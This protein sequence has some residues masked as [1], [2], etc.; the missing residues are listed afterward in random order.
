MIR[1]VLG[2]DFKVERVNTVNECLVGE[3]SEDHTVVQRGDTVVG[4]VAEEA[5]RVWE[6]VYMNEF[7]KI[8]RRRLMKGL[9]GE[10]QNLK[11]SGSK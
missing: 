7:R 2:Q 8:Q 1:C 4:W 3:S 5:L 11:I 10:K 6:G 9:K